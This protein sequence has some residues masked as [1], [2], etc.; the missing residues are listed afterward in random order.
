MT[1]RFV[2]GFS[3]QLAL[4]LG[5]S[6]I[7]GAVQ[8]QNYDN[9]SNQNSANISIQSGLCQEVAA[10]LQSGDLIFM[11]SGNSLFKKIAEATKSWTTHV[12]IAMRS[13]GG[14]WGMYEAKLMF[15]TLSPLCNF[16]DR[17][18]QGG[19]IAIL[20]YRTEFSRTDLLQIKMES[21]ARLGR[22]YNIGFDYDSP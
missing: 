3:L 19:K 12:G 5:L 4:I 6:S 17:A 2:V 1:I 13:A 10:Q 21:E 8:N 7:A 18:G 14:D 22:A 11:A 20:R 9:R 15:S 16:L